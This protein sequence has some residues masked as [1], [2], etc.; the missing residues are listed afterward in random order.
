[1]PGIIRQPQFQGWGQAFAAQVFG[2][3]PDPFDNLLHGF[4]S[5]FGPGPWLGCWHL[6][7]NLQ[8]LDSVLAL[9]AILFAK[10]IQQTTLASLPRP[11]YRRR[12]RSNCSF[13]SLIRCMCIAFF[14]VSF[15]HE[16][17]NAFS[18]H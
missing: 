11:T 17:T 9:I 18:S 5:R 10:L 4:I 3:V 7:L 8:Q 1:M 13:R 16:A 14:W 2:A 12:M 6:R 15:S